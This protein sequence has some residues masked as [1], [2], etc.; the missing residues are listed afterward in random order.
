MDVRIP[1]KSELAADIALVSNTDPL[2]HRLLAWR[3]NIGAH[4]N[5][6]ETITPNSV[7]VD[8]LE[9]VEIGELLERAIHILNK[10]SLLF[11]ALAYSTSM[12]GADDYK[13]VLNCIR[14][15][16]AARNREFTEEMAKY[17][18]SSP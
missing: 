12:V 3:N 1:D 10:Y 11:G 14:K 4:R 15:D 13:Y 5:P 18:K 9:F 8:P 17:E 6:R 2:V 16:L 7:I